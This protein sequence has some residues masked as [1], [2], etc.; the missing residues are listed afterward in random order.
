MFL[1]LSARVEFSPTLHTAVNSRVTSPARRVLK[2]MWVRFPADNK[3]DETRQRITNQSF[4]QF[5]NQPAILEHGYCPRRRGHHQRNGSGPDG[6]C[7]RGNVARS[8]T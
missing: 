1:R 2:I 7:K 4:V 3:E 5:E 8:E 6:H